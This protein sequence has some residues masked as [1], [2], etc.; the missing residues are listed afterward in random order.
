MNKKGQTLIM[1]VILLPLLIGVCAFVIDI[2]LI[3]YEKNKLQNIIRSVEI[4]KVDKNLKI[5]GI[6]EYRKK[7]KGNCVNITYYKDSVFGRIVGIK[8][9]KI[10]ASSC[11]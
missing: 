9:Y 8:T 11:E 1:F 10:S 7:E 3:T 2:G 5:N 6:K 4:N